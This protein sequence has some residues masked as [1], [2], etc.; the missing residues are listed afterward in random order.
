[1][2]KMFRVMAVV[3]MGFYASLAGAAGMGAMV[4]NP[5][6]R[7]APPTAA[8]LGAFM[9]LHNH[10]TQ[11]LVLVGAECAAAG[12]VQLHRTVMEG[13]MARMVRQGSIEVPS[14]GQLEFKPGDFH[15]MLMK[16]KRVLK[17]GEKVDITLKFKDGSSLPVTFEVRGGM[18]TPMDHG[19]MHHNH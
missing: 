13:G 4:E 11:P 16:P 17:A 2:V 6:V 8:A 12:E 3:L 1:M 19:K 10:S 7:E 5:W 9:M 18:G 15:L 14:H